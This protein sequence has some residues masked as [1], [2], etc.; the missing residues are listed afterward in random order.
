MFPELARL[1]LELWFDSQWVSEMFQL[2]WAD[3]LKPCPAGQMWPFCIWCS[4]FHL[5][6]SGAGSHCISQKHM[7]G[8]HYEANDSAWV[9]AQPDALAH[10]QASAHREQWPL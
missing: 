4:K 7:K 6:V 10:V 8:L 9:G 1:G 3:I 2:Q 5:P